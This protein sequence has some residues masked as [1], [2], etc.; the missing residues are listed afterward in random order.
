[1]RAIV[2]VPWGPH[3]GTRVVL[4]PGE[5]L[6]V[7]RHST[8]LDLMRDPHV[9]RVHFE[10]E[11]DG[12]RCRVRDKDSV[13]G[14]MLNG[15]AVKEAEVRSGDFIRAGDTVLSVSF[16]GFSRRRPRP[17]ILG[18]ASA[19]ITRERKAAVLAALAAEKEPLF[20]I[21]DPTRSD[22]VL[23]LLREAV[24]Y[25]RSL[26]EGAEGDAMSDVAPYLV[27]LPDKRSRLVVS[28]VQEGWM[29]RFGIFLTSARPFKEVRRHFR[30]WLMLQ[31]EETRERLYFRYY[32]PVTLRVFLPTCTPHKRELFYDEVSAFIVEGE[33][34]EV[35]RFSEGHDEPEVV[36]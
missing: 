11:W 23:E 21:L 17:K 7:G 2:E 10:L 28:L 13:M 19:S 33:R 3:R 6:R 26:Y 16:E 25:S 5:T 35:L 9:S 15:E 1:M 24:E 34:G 22:R 32:D 18:R 4:A 12:A 8:D 27:E 29:R 14:T 31:E 30:R 36:G 20:A